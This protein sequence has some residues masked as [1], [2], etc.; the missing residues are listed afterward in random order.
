MMFAAVVAQAASKEVTVGHIVYSANT[1]SKTAKVIGFTDGI[2]GLNYRVNIKDAVTVDGVS[3]KVT[4][5]GNKAFYCAHMDK[6][7][8]PSTVKTIGTEAFAGNCLE[9]L[10]LPE[11]LEIIGV[12]AF[13]GAIS[14]SLSLTIPKKVKIIRKNAFRDCE[15]KEVTFLNNNMELIGDFAFQYNLFTTFTVPECDELGKGVLCGNVKLKTAVI[16]GT[17]QVLGDQ[18]FSNCWALESVTIPSSVKEIGYAC[19]FGCR[20][21]KTFPTMSGLQVIGENAFYECTFTT[22]NNLPSTLEI[23]GVEAFHNNPNLTEVTIPKSVRNIMEYAFDY[24]QNIKKVTVLGDSPALGQVPV[25]PELG[26]YGFSKDT[27]YNATL[28]V[29][30]NTLETYKS[31]R[32]WMCFRHIVDPGASGIEAIGGEDAAGGRAVIYD[33]DGRR[34]FETSA[35][36]GTMPQLPSGIYILDSKGER[37]KIRL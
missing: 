2:E 22:L 27:Y 10:K 36:D 6:I 21:L 15:L 12:G 18:F 17:P 24:C 35:W 16:K 7:G 28:Y 20:S 34:V 8:M 13:D 29:P 4:A 11:D 9:T 14:K 19:F 1:S 25:I 26:V 32:E 33:L 31:H 37:R 23:I 30:R 3:C 5:I